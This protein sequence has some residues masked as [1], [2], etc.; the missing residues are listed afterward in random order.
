MRIKIRIL[1]LF[2]FLGCGCLSFPVYAENDVIVVNKTERL[3]D[4][5]SVEEMFDKEIQRDGLVYSLDHIEIIEK[6][7]VSRI[8]PK[9]SITE[10]YPMYDDEGFVYEIPTNLK[11]EYRL[12]DVATAS[13]LLPPSVHTV[14][15]EE[16]YFVVDEKDVPKELDIEYIDT[17][18]GERYVDTFP[19]MDIKLLEQNWV[20][21][22]DI[23]IRFNDYNADTYIINGVTYGNSGIPDIT[24]NEN[25]ILELA[26]MDLNTTQIKDVVWAGNEYS[27]NGR[28]YRDAIVKT[29][30]CVKHYSCRYG[31]EITFPER[32]GTHQIATFQK[33]E[34]ALKT[35]ILY[36]IE[37]TATY[38][39]TQTNT[40]E[41]YFKI[42]FIIGAFVIGVVALIAGK[43]L[44]RK[45]CRKDEYL[46][47]KYR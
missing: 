30:Q 14:D 6:K 1:S 27:T 38:A 9:D 34:Q 47:K 22:E 26:G 35:P 3:S 16:E 13:C 36:D 4:P 44:I 5:D 33:D 32:T 8:N 28:I 20:D 25:Y 12:V 24:G 2:F 41:R 15:S 21:G 29:S 42:P 11:E 46:G 45:K 19:L 39:L 43:I 40:D 18:T 7:E 37:A 23:R 31:G 10:S 17:G